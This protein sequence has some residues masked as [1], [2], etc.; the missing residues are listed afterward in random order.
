V[1][2]LEVGVLRVRPRLA[3]DDRAGRERQRRAAA[4]DALAVAFH[5]ELLQV[6]GQPLQR[7]RVGRDAAAREAVE[8]AVPDVDEAEQ[9][10]QVALDRRLRE[11]L[12]HRARAGEQLAKALGADRDRDRQADR[13]PQRV[14]AAD[15]VPE[16]EGARDAEARRRLDVARRG[17]EVL[18]DPRAARATNQA[19]AVSALVIV[20]CVVK[21]LLATT[22]SVSAGATRASTEA[23][24]APST[25]ATK[26][27]DRPGCATSARART[28]ICGPRSL[29][30]MPMLTTWRRR[31]G[32]RRRRACATRLGE[33]QHR[34]E[35]ARGRRRRTGRCRAAR[36]ARVQ[37]RAP[38][39]V[40]I[41]ARRASRRAAPRR[42]IRAPG[43][44]GK[45]SVA[46]ST[47]FFDRS[48]KTSGASNDID[49]NR[50]GSRANASRRSKPRPWASKWPAS[51]AQAAGAV[52][53]C[54]R[55]RVVHQEHGGAVHSADPISR[56]TWSREA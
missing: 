21:V 29:P 36:A 30:P 26:W 49:S 19:R 28:A 44:R 33:G 51:A 37:H 46:A 25:L 9:H 1:Q 27:N 41:A 20:S 54:N 3:P 18:F 39:G 11:V 47:R 22:K 42:R 35:D 52:A 6:G 24:S 12:V 53:A 8:V 15:P 38:L 10:R 5:L 48:A 13:R 23:R 31:P 17:D 16:A 56:S 2:H 14:A 50:R 34:V 40:L 55:R 7:L 43:R 4:V 45:R 32:P